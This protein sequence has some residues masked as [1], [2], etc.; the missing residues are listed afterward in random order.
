MSFNVFGKYNAQKND[1]V[2]L[3][4]KGDKIQLS[5]VFSVFPID[6]LAVLERYSSKG[7]LN[8]N[9]HL[10]GEMSQNKSLLFEADFNA[11]KASF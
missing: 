8:F 4:I 11:D 3:Y 10:F 9:A 6:Y 5:E 1:L 7:N 2:D